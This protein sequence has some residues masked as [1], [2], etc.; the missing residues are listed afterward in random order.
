[1]CLCCLACLLDLLVWYVLL[2]LLGLL[3]YLELLEIHF[4]F[5]VLL[6]KKVTYGQLHLLVLG[7]GRGL[8]MSGAS[9][10]AVVLL[11]LS[12][13][14]GLIRSDEDFGVSAAVSS[15][16]LAPNENVALLL[17]DRFDDP[18]E[19]IPLGF[20]VAGN[21]VLGFWNAWFLRSYAYWS[22]L[23]HSQRRL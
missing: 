1:M 11:G 6:S 5:R 2:D 4:D 21:K 22:T 9:E 13:S 19:N 16:F 3:V 12:V 17:V 7:R 15:S 14:F 20:A 10:T 8:V 18:K 23:R